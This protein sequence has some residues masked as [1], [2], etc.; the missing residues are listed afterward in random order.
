MLVAVIALRHALTHKKTLPC[1]LLS[2]WDKRLWV[3]KG[4][5]VRIIA[6]NCSKALEILVGILISLHN[7]RQYIWLPIQIKRHYGQLIS[8]SSWRCDT[9]HYCRFVFTTSIFLQGIIQ[10]NVYRYTC[11]VYHKGLSKGQ[12]SN[13][14]WNRQCA[15]NLCSFKEVSWEIWNMMLYSNLKT[16]HL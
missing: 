12:F 5:F 1:I 10:N 7:N 13:I 3:M 9:L 2:I 4:L 11:V 15:L 16:S 8:A 6:K 14:I